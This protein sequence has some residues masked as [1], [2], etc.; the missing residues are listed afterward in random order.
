MKKLLVLI[1]LGSFLFSCSNPPEESVEA[2]NETTTTE[3]I[4]TTTTTTTTTIP[5]IDYDEYGV[6][7]LDIS[8]DMK[9]QLD[10]LAVH[11]AE[12][13]GI[14][15]TKEPKFRLY[16]LKGYQ[17]YNEL[18]YLDEFE[19]DYEKGEWER[20]VLSEQLWG[21]TTSTPSAMKQLLVEFM[22]CSSAGSYNLKDELI[23]VPIKR[24]Q[25]K[26]N[27]W[28]QSVLV[29]EL[30]HT[31]QGQVVDLKTWYEGMEELDDYSN[32][33]GRRAIMEAQ[34]DLI[35]A[36]W[37]SNLDVY[38]RQQMNTERPNITC[39]VELPAYFYIP[40]DLY[41]SFGPQLV[42]KIKIKGGMAAI[43]EA[44]H[45]LPTAE[46]IYS[47][48]KYFAKEVYEDIQ[49]NEIEIEGWTVIDQGAIDSLDIVYLVQGSVGRQVAVPAGIGIGGGKW[50]DY[51]DEDNNL[52]MTTKI[53]GDTP[54]DLLEILSSFRLGTFSQKRFGDGEEKYSGFFVSTLVNTGADSG[55]F[56]EAWI[57]S[58]GEYVRMVI[59][60]VSG[61]IDDLFNSKQLLDY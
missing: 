11:V 55:I 10:D 61:I 21:L 57:S 1:L 46:Q 12:K 43:N 34:A 30:T 20:A 42:K 2:I 59:S 51:I 33:A 53:S 48:E 31:L 9:Q 25:K 18:S 36:Y 14:E 13:V 52:F 24:N 56:T 29:H 16:T 26:L 40:N 50:V 58:D 32:Y 5:E 54:E 22:R 35:Q 6:E 3:I 47:S 49:I 17:D 41:Y 37:E 23:R 19:K 38:D 39:A 45:E 28:E 44:L 4:T 60:S 15:Y 27:L 8:K 7:I